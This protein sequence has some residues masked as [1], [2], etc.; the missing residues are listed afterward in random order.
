MTSRRHDAGRAG[1]RQVLVWRDR[2]LPG[3]ET[4]IRNQ[5]DAMTR[6]EPTLAGSWDVESALRRDTD[7]VLFDASVRGRIE[8]RLF[9]IFGWSPRLNRLL[10]QRGISLIHAHFGMGAVNIARAAR[11]HRIPLVVTV[12][13]NDVTR[14]DLRADSGDREGRAYARR[15]TR[16]LRDAAAVIAVSDFIARETRSGYGVPAQKVKVLPIGIPIDPPQGEVEAEW[17][18]LFVGRLVAKKGVSDLLTAVEI[19]GRK[20]PP[21]SLRIIGDGK[22]RTDLEA[23]AA[24]RGVDATFTGE[25][26]PDEVSDAMARSSI[27]V[28]PSRT[29]PDG[30]AEGFGMV[31]LEAA[32][33][34]RPVIAYDHGG[35]GEAVVNGVTGILLPE[36]DVRGLA[37]AIVRLLED[38]R[39]QRQ[40]GDAGRRRLRDR[41]DIRTC[42]AELETEFDRVQGGGR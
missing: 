31:F 14:R 20:I 9:T 42:T 35:V 39:M 25:L 21:P 38:R 10:A 28:A 34:G 13:G 36:G 40:M 24:A 23:E 19:A 32:Q 41:F 33:A 29:A 8:R 3:S 15:L 11:R 16:A 26:S 18:L 7:V 4:F 37:D 17:D 27:F 6:W 5:V 12:H 30:D 2:I 1:D 22:L